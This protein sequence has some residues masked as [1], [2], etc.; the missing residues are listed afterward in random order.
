MGKKKGGEDGD[1]SRIKSCC[2]LELY[3][4]TEYKPYMLQW[5]RIN[6][7]NK[8]DNGKRQFRKDR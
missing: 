2:V 6:N 8:N 4:I 3:N 5:D 1:I 7:V